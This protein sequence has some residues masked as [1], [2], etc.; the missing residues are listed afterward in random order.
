M[1]KKTVFRLAV[2]WLDHLLTKKPEDSG[3]EIVVSFISCNPM[4]NYE[5]HHATEFSLV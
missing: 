1:K 3:Y 5:L 4:S 2:D